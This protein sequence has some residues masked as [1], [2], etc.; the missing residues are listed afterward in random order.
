MGSVDEK[1]GCVMRNNDL[2]PSI[3]GSCQ[4]NWSLEADMGCIELGWRVERAMDLETVTGWSALWEL[5]YEQY[6]SERS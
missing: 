6:L 5:S 3:D 2:G 4:P 1:G